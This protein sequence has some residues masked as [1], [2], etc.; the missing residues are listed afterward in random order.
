MHGAAINV[1]SVEADYSDKTAVPLS[2]KL[3]CHSEQSLNVRESQDEFL[4]QRTANRLSLSR[5]QL[6]FKKLSTEKIFF[7]QRFDKQQE[8]SRF[9]PENF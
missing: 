8:L 1:E 7:A 5:F 6:N 3:I 4:L 9:Q 2:R